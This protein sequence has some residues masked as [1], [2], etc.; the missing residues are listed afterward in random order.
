MS[1]KKTCGL[2]LLLAVCLVS[3]NQKNEKE[4]AFIQEN[5]EFAEAQTR[6]MLEKVNGLEKRRYP[7]TMNNDGKFVATGMYDWTPGFFPGSL[8]YLYELSNDQFWLKE[9]EDWT[10]SLEKLKFFTGH[11]DLGFMMYCSY[12]NALRLAPKAEYDSIL[13]TSAGS[14]ASRYSPITETIKS[15]NYRKAWNDT[16]EWFYPVIIDN[17][18]NLELLTQGSRLAKND[19]YKNIAITHANTTLKNQFRNDFT[20]F[21][22]V[23]YDPETGDVLNQATCQGYSD[24]SVWARG[25][26]WAIYGYA[27]M[28]RETGIQE[29]LTAS[30][31]MADWY[32]NN[33]PEDLVPLWD[34]NV[35]QPGY[36]PEEK[37][38]AL[39]F[40][41]ENLKDASAAAITCSALFELGEL[42]KDKKYNE[43]AIAMLHMLASDK[44]RAPLGE[45]ANFLLMHSVGSIPHINEIDKPLVYADYYFLESLVR[46][47]NLLETGSIYGKTKA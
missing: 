31:K 47:K 37:S 14:L 26:A 22:V 17:M 40:K 12:G 7:R 15:W 41:G 1:I 30:E 24:N 46:Y 45:N 38:Y 25:Q 39:Q 28:Y 13:I 19:E 3:C 9:A 36:T 4:L 35:D 6:L 5:L 16:V 2:L 11:H 20:N 21:H 33:L 23:N 10:H 29:Y 18:M 42:S 27:M 34:F 43:K 32:L 8:W 44:Y